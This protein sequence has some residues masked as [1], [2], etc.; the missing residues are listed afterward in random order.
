MR[1]EVQERVREN[2]PTVEVDSVSVAEYVEQSDLVDRIANHAKSSGLEI[3]DEDELHGSGFSDVVV[4]AGAVQL[5]TIAE[6]DAVLES[7]RPRTEDYFERFVQ[8]RARSR[9]D[10]ELQHKIMGDKAHFIAMTLVGNYR[11]ELDDDELREELSWH[12]EYFQ[13]AR[14]AGDVFE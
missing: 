11:D 14:R 3:G 9:G 2:D 8:L 7:V 4:V 12:T 1:R 10:E 6:L 13:D 5:Q